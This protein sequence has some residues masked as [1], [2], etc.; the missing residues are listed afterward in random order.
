MPPSNDEY[1]PPNID[2]LLNIDSDAYVRLLRHYGPRALARCRAALKRHGLGLSDVETIDCLQEAGLRLLE[3]LQRLTF[4]HANQMGTWLVVT[5]ERICLDRIAAQRRQD[6]LT[7]EY[8]AQATA[9]SSYRDLESIIAVRQLLESCSDEER[10]LL[11]ERYYLSLTNREIAQRT[12]DTPEAVRQRT[13]R[14]LKRL[15]KTL[16]PPVAD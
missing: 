4:D 11:F 5:A 9:M 3:R 12:G 16:I 10:L 15:R 1:T 6:D 14:L 2:A 7:R 8:Q 13:S